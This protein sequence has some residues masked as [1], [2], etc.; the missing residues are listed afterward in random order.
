MTLQTP[1]GPPGG[2]HLRLLRV[3][4]QGSC[5]VLAGPKNVLYEL[6]ASGAVQVV[7]SHLGI[8]LD[9]QCEVALCL[10]ELSTK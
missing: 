3:K 9:G 5:N 6:P 7:L 8:V 10:L 1:S 4:D 2:T